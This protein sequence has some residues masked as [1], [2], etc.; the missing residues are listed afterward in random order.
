MKNV[1][2]ILFN[3]VCEKLFPL[4]NVGLAVFIVDSGLPVPNP[5][6]PTATSR[7]NT[8]S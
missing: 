5:N 2:F 8:I 1:L 4:T 3:G 7:Y 6:S